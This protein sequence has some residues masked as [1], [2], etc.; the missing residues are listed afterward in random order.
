M[1]DAITPG[2]YLVFA[3]TS[4]DFAADGTAKVIDLLNEAINEPYVVSTQG[5]SSGS[6]TAST[7]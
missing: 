1:R 4:L 2:S 3:H 5:R 6:S 7:W